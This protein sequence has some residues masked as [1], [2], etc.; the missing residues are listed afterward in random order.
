MQE[1]EA[2]SYLKVGDHLLNAADTRYPV[3]GL[4][5]TLATRRRLEKAVSLRTQVAVDHIRLE[6]TLD[7]QLARQEAAIPLPATSR[8]VARRRIVPVVEF[9]GL[10]PPRSNAGK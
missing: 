2:L 6:R 4:T 5:K 10:P 1:L 8:H 3:K 9:D 7:L